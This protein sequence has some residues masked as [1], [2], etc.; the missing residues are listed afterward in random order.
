MPC[1][2]ASSARVSPLTSRDTSKIMKSSAV[3]VLPTVTVTSAEIIRSSAV[4]LLVSAA[5]DAGVGKAVVRT[6]SFPRDVA[7]I[8]HKT[9]F[10]V[11]PVA[12]QMK[13]QT[14]VPS[15]QDLTALKDYFNTRYALY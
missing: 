2:L 14:S 7:A 5:G 6:S 15:S 1:N 4:V 13:E 3:G 11:V 10:A 9:V 8:A 12:D